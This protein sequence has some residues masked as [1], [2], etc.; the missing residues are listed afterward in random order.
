MRFYSFF[1]MDQQ[2]LKT[3]EHKLVLVLSSFSVV[4]AYKVF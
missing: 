1:R 3:L 4:Y 2:S